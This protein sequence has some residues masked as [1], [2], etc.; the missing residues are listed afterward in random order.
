MDSV[1][2]SGD[3]FGCWEENKKVWG[4]LVQYRL[5]NEGVL[6][7]PRG[8]AMVRRVKMC[9]TVHVVKLEN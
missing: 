7:R 2:M 5:S 4:E 9:T 3:A 1:S 8:V 6:L